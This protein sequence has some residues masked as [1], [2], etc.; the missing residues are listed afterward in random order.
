MSSSPASTDNAALAAGEPA[1]P[2]LGDDTPTPEP[3]ASTAGGAVDLPPRRDMIDLLLALFDRLGAILPPLAILALGAGVAYL[4]AICVT[5]ALLRRSVAAQAFFVNVLAEMMWSGYAILLMIGVGIAITSIIQLTL[6]PR[7]WVWRW[8]ARRLG[9]PVAWAATLLW[10]AT[11]G[12]EAF[13]IG[14]GF[15]LWAGPRYIELRAALGLAPT[16][17]GLLLVSIL[18]APLLALL[19]EWCARFGLA[20]LRR[21][22]REI[23]LL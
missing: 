3:S 8:L 14:W 13:L 20:R 9:W 4:G 23:I 22:L 21:G 12:V 1:A 18:V 7:G 6:W 19:P 17:D 5:T 11:A 16:P 2:T 10:G 15:E